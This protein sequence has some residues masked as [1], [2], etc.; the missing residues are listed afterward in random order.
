MF[1]RV[2]YM[3][4]VL[5][6][7]KVSIQNYDY[8]DFFLG[9]FYGILCKKSFCDSRCNIWDAAVEIGKQKDADLSAEFTLIVL[10][11]KHGV[12]R[13]CHVT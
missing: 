8:I 6:D 1:V 7:S 4:Y 10:G 2:Q 3:I 5:N 9:S 12:S 11:S 13:M